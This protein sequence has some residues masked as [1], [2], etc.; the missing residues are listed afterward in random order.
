MR[1]H[2]CFRD[3]KVGFERPTKHQRF[4]LVLSRFF[5]RPGCSVNGAGHLQGTIHHS[6]TSFIR[7]IVHSQE[8]QSQVEHDPLSH[9]KILTDAHHETASSRTGKS[10]PVEFPQPNTDKRRCTQQDKLLLANLGFLAQKRLAR[11]L[12]LNRSEA[13]ALI[14]FQL[15]EFIR[16]GKHSVA[17]LMQLGKEMLGR[18]HVLEGVEFAIHDV[19]V[20]GT[21]PV[22][23]SPSLR[24]R[25][26]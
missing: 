2:F 17:D 16:D 8:R 7:D 12:K 10:A 1:E 15:Q 4:G 24:K 23:R 25:R 19:Q 26:C 22:S 18:R 5:G 11:G 13:I 21:F 20:E 9:P 3:K 14:A 6:G